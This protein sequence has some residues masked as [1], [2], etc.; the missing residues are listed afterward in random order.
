MDDACL[1]ICS[2]DTRTLKHI[3]LRDTVSLFLM[4]ISFDNQEEQ[5]N[6]N[7]N[8]CLHVHSLMQDQISIIT[9]N[10]LTLLPASM[11]DVAMYNL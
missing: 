6:L 4:G 8:L 7:V 1:T 9:T 11:T 3:F 5:R 10:L 2:Q